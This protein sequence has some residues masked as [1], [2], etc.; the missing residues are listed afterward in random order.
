MISWIIEYCSLVFGSS[1]DDYRKAMFVN[2][3]EVVEKAR[4]REH[5]HVSQHFWGHA[6]PWE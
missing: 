4:D 5:N 3:F 2:E 6:W 1:Q